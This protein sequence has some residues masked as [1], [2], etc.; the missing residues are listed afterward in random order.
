RLL[1]P[2]AFGRM[3]RNYVR[4]IARFK[5][6]EEIA[7]DALDEDLYRGYPVMEFKPNWRDAPE[8][9]YA[10]KLVMRSFGTGKDEV[11]DEAEIP[12]PVHSFRWTC[13]TRED[14]LQFRKWL[15]ARRGRQKAV[16]LPTF[17]DDLALA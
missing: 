16:W 11:E 9:D 13:L 17:A 14:V 10:R 4:G 2:R 5:T 15:Y 12:L 8:I 3:H 7:G 1:D 6:T